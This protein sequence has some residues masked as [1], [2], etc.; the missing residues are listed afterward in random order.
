LAGMQFG[1][2]IDALVAGAGSGNGKK[3]QSGNPL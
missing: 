2:E 3:E 1:E